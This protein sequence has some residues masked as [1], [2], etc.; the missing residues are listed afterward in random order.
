MVATI[1]LFRD[2][3]I[4]PQLN[5]IGK[6]LHVWVKIVSL[7]LLQTQQKQQQIRLPMEA[8]VLTLHK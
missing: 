6:A 7:H 5:K 3:L 1:L 4:D 8:M 2:K